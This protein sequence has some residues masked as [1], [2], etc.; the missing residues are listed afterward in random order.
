MKLMYDAM[1][2]VL[3]M[4]E[5]IRVKGREKE[6]D[7]KRKEWRRKTD[8]ENKKIKKIKINNTGNIP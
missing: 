7:R 6:I 4:G 1:E 5:W 3:R 8:R 2:W